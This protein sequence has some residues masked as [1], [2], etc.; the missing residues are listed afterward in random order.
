MSQDKQNQE[1]QIEDKPIEG[2]EYDG[3]HELDNPLPGW[4]LTT[5]YLTIIFAAIYWVYYEFG[6][7][8]TSNEYLKADMESI[9]S[10]QA[11]VEG[12]KQEISEKSLLAMV[13][14][15]EALSAGKAEYIVKCA[16]CHGAE[17]Q[18]LIGPNITDDYWIHGDGSIAAILK[19]AN[20]GVLDKGMPPWKG[21]IA[22]DLLEKVSVYIYSI[23]GSNPA[24][25]KPPQGEKI[26]EK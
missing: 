3:I 18:G 16:A 8:P 7:G 20:E 26:G 12:A 22:D 4:W 15:E 5:F 11:K 25:A 10:L 2:H 19:V 13:K 24:G 14:D 23:R 1:N 9:Q 6:S 17:G 21:V